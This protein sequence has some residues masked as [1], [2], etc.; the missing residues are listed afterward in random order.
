MNTSIKPSSDRNARQQRSTFTAV[1]AKTWSPTTSRFLR[2]EIACIAARGPTPFEVKAW[3]KLF[4]P[5]GRELPGAEG[6]Q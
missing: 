4:N 6:T 2:N 1:D 3:P 5:T